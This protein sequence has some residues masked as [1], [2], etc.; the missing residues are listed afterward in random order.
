MM[1]DAKEVVRKCGSC[2]RYASQI[3]AP[4]TPMKPI[5][6]ACPFDQWR[7]DILGPFPP[8]RAQ[9]K[10]IVVAVEY[11]SKWV[12]AEGVARIVEGEMI[13]FIWKNIICRLGIPRVLI[14]NNSIQFQGKQITA[15]L[16]ELKI[17]QNFMTVDH[18]QANGQTEVTNRTT[19]LKSRLQ[20][21]D[22][23]MMNYLSMLWAYR[24]T[25]RST[26][27]ETPF[28]LIYDFE[29]II[30][31]EIGEKS[32]RIA[33]YDPAT[34]KEER[35]FDLTMVEGKRDAAHAKILHHKGLML[36]NYN[37]K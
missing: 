10:F 24:T 17:Q 7:I 37:K 13:N 30:P 11:F 33:I 35:S 2:Q 4:A 31:A 9:K 12:E 20:S 22:R 15:W 36:K 3:H 18:P 8:A 14:S 25:P 21:K 27:G 29:A 23:G 32:P 26:T 6:I 5:Q 34:N 16:K 19:D 28:C 1:K